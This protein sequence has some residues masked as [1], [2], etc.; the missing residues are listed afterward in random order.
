[1]S[2]ASDFIIE[3]GILTKYVGTGGDVVIPEGVTSIGNSAFSWCRRLTSVTIPDSV[4]SIDNCAFEGCSNL[5][6]VYI[7]DLAA[8]CEIKFGYY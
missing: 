1:M 6:A 7:S 5:N 4:T 2:S 8:W 3:N